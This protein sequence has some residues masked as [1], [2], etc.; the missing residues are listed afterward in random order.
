MKSRGHGNSGAGSYEGA[1]EPFAVPD[2]AM[3]LSARDNL[4]PRLRHAIDFA[5]REWSAVQAQQFIDAGTD[6]DELAALIEAQTRLD[7]DKRRKESEE[8][9]RQ[10]PVRRTRN[11]LR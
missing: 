5:T 11:L 1:S 8:C 10:N 4:S 3:E 2:L 6:A 9:V 7:H